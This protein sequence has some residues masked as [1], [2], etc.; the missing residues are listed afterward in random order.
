MLIAI[1]AMAART[2]FQAVALGLAVVVLCASMWI[3]TEAVHVVTE[4][5]RA[6]GQHAIPER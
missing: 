6:I 4:R 2:R 1:A 3:N 5:V